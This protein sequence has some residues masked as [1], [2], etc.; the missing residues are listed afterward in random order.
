MF[1]LLCFLKG[2]LDL[3][4]FVEDLIMSQIVDILDMIVC[5]GSALK[6]FAGF[7]WVDTLQDAQTTEVLKRKLK[8]LDSFRTSD[9]LG[10]LT[11]NILCTELALWLS[12]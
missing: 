10:C 4:E 3:S 9:V 2:S 5:F 12:W 6:F 8:L 11:L 1:I 7:S